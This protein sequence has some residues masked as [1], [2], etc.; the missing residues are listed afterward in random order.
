MVFKT[1]IKNNILKKLSFFDKTI[2]IYLF[3]LLF[4]LAYTFNINF[5]NG[6]E[7]THLLL[8]VFY[9]D[10][11]HYLIK[12]MDFSFNNAYQYAIRYLVT[13]PKLQIAYPPLYH[14]TNVLAFSIFGVSFFISRLINSIYA[15]MSFLV[16]Y[17]IIKKFFNSK[18]AFIS[19]FLFSFSPISVYYSSRVMMDSCVFF[20]FLLSIYIFILAM[21][22]GKKKYFILTGILVFCATISKQMGGIIIFFFSLVLLIKII[23]EKERRIEN[24][25]FI[26]VLILS[27][28]L[29]LLPYL[30]ILYKAG[31]F[32]INKIVAIDYAQVQG[33]STTPLDPKF[34]LYYPI[35]LINVKSINSLV[36][37]PL[38]LLSFV[39]YIYNKNSLWKNHLLFFL[40][41]FIILSL[42]PNKEPRFAQFF[43]LPT[44]LTLAYYLN[45]INK[46]IVLLFLT[47]YIIITL[48]IFLPTISYYPVESVVTYVHE[49]I[50]K[51]GNVALFSDDTPSHSSV[52]MWYLNNLDK[53][54]T[55]R[56]Y[57]SCIF[58]DKNKQQLLQTLEDNNI[59]FVVY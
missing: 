21:K 9:K 34:W 24:L 10:L 51:N 41:F 12:T 32:E 54:K 18:I 45:K 50:V 4:F 16:F 30:F 49:N 20:W 55:I 43:L 42:I 29:P 6:D 19:T 37:L 15:C 36:F 56:T 38:F 35:E 31:G 13:Y 27:F 59:Y 46:G 7:G 44:F 58:D 26:T 3:L 1:K 11:I 52:F 25:K 22:E 33:E 14:L 53:N 40:V 39:I 47:A 28:S 8:S 57:R 2:I 17:L 5:L 48:F 23:L